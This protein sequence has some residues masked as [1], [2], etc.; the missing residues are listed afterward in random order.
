MGDREKAPSRNKVLMEEGRK[1]IRITVSAAL[2]AR[3]DAIIEE[4][5]LLRDRQ[6][7]AGLKHEEGSITRG[8][9][10]C[11]AIEAHVGRVESLRKRF[12]LKLPPKPK[13]G[14][15]PKRG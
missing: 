11:L 3:L 7:R 15:P 10:A 8:S 13:L 5:R 1:E 12:P 2:L 9:E 6:M 4:K 14:R